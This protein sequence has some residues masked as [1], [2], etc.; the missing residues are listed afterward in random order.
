MIGSIESGAV[1]MFCSQQKYLLAHQWI[2]SRHLHSQLHCV[3]T[4]SLFMSCFY[5][6]Q[7]H[8]SI[9]GVVFLRKTLNCDPLCDI[10]SS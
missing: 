6:R 1:D 7:T 5:L 4:F 3:C 2:D 8:R 10:F 9:C